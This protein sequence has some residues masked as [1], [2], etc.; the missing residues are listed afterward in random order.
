VSHDGPQTPAWRLQSAVTRRLQELRIPFDPMVV[1]GLFAATAVATGSYGGGCIE[2]GLPPRLH[3]GYTGRSGQGSC[4]LPAGT[5]HHLSFALHASILARSKFSWDCLVREH[6]KLGMA[7]M[8]Q[9]RRRCAMRLAV[10]EYSAHGRCGMGRCAI[11]PVERS[12]VATLSW[13]GLLWLRR[14]HAVG[15]VSLSVVWPCGRRSAARALRPSRRWL[16]AV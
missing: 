12:L 3:T 11:Y 8:A 10:S 5:A 13:L 14:G 1:G 7:G 16:E 4:P 15:W 2:G 6:S 9:G